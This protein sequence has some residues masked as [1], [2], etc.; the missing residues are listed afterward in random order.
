MPD[1][2]LVERGEPLKDGTAPCDARLARVDDRDP[3]SRGFPIAELLTS[4]RIDNLRSYTWRVPLWL[5]Q[6]RRGAC[7]GFAWAHE[8]AARPAVIDGVTDSFAHDV[9]YWEA[10]KR[11]R[12]PGG[13]YPGARPIVA[14]TSVLAAAKVVRDLGFIDEYRWAF[15]VE[16]LLAALG[17]FGPVIFGCSW[18]E[19]MMEPD[20]KEAHFVAPT[21]RRMGKHCVLINGVRISRRGRELDE[22]ASWVR[23]HNSFGKGWGENGGA[24]LYVSDLRLLLSGADMC[25]PVGRRRKHAVAGFR[26]GASELRV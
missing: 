12:Y 10:Q 11:D 1:E 24:K 22:H 4:R 25:V 2:P 6:G 19:G 20:P 21:G 8:L 7:V 5:D 9:L 18:Y 13:S 15:S 3:R 26:V 16:E 23:F 14:G 17:Y